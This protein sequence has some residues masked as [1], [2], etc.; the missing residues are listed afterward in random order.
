M[1]DRALDD[2]G[3]WQSVPLTHTTCVRKLGCSIEQSA[4][5]LA[6]TWGCALYW[7]PGQLDGKGMFHG[8]CVKE[9]PREAHTGTSLYFREARESQADAGLAGISAQ[10]PRCKAEAML[11]RGACEPSGLQGQL[12]LFT[13]KSD[14][15]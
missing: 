6:S 10:A 15:K 8:I 2:F 11:E 14:Y 5:R 9:E 13:S 1:Y 12:C 7:L 3:G 4:H